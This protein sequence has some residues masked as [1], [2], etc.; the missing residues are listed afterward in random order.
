MFGSWVGILLLI[1][2]VFVLWLVLRGIVDLVAWFRD[3][4]LDDAIESRRK[5]REQ[6]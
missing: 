1:A 6:P 3:E 2:G 5:D 4:F